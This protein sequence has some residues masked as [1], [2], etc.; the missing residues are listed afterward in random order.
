MT[1]TDIVEDKS[2]LMNLFGW[3]RPKKADAEPPE[4]PLRRK[5]DREAAEAR[6][7][8]NAPWRFDEGPTRRPVG[9]K[10]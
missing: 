10:P 8:K 5:P 1:D 9:R 7:R 2:P 6:A 4:T 3:K